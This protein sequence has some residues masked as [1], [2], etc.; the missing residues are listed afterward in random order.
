MS[1]GDDARKKGVLQSDV[2][3]P[4]EPLIGILPSSSQE[5]GESSNPNLT[6]WADQA[7]ELDSN[8][9]VNPKPAQKKSRAAVACG[10]RDP[11]RGMELKYVP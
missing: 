10:N 2:S 7:E 9:I 5:K 1:N 3:T 8:L 6:I 11:A 4:I